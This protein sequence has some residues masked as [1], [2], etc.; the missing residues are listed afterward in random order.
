MAAAGVVAVLGVIAAGAGSSG[1][2]TPAVVHGRLLVGRRGNGL[3]RP[4]TRVPASDLGLRV[5]VDGR[6]GVAINTGSSL[7]DVTYPVATSDGGRTWRV[8]GPELHIPA[9]DGPDGVTQVTAARPS[10]YVVYGG[11]QGANSVVVSSDRGRH[12]YRAYLPDG[13]VA[14]VVATGRTLDAFTGATGAWVSRD[15]GRSWRHLASVPL[16]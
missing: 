3:L 6:H 15:G 2:A 1:A 8:D 5:F 13:T 10:T 11:P 12:W 14:A 9:A 7:G 4:G 16:D